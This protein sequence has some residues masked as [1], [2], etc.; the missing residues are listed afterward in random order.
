MGRQRTG[1]LIDLEDLDEEEWEID[2]EEEI[3]RPR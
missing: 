2:M 3:V 1:G